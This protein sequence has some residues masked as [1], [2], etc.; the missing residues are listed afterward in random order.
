[1]AWINLFFAMTVSS[2]V[3]RATNSL[4]TAAKRLEVTQLSVTLAE[5]NLKAE[6]A[7]FTLG[8]STSYDVLFRIDELTTARA[9]A[10]SARIEYV[11]AKVQLQAL[12]G[13]ILPAFGLDLVSRAGADQ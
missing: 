2:G 10:L 8:R 6:Q 9:N 1:M 5:E 3:L 12:T 13:E 4:R 11:K 7:K